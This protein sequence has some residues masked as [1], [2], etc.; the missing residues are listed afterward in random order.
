LHL[1]HDSRRYDSSRRR[2]RHKRTKLF[3]ADAPQPKRR[4]ENRDSGASQ[5]YRSQQGGAT[6][7]SSVV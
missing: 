4:T 7:I 1:R 3:A 5:Q 2:F 6:V